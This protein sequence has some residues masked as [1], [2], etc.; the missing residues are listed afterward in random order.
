MWQG[1]LFSNLLV[2]FILLTL[3]AIVYC[4]VTRK[5][6]VDLIKEIKEMFSEVEE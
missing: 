1:N 6:L 5:T 3:A 4:K 2:V